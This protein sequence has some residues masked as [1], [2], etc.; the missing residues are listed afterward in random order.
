[1]SASKDLS[2][3]NDKYSMGSYNPTPEELQSYLNGI[4]KGIRIAPKRH[5]D[6][7]YIEVYAK[8]RWRHNGELFGPVDVW[9]EIYNY[10]C[11]YEK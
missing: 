3:K 11:Y 4:R 9:K 2:R 7:W 10:Y 5:K 1:M 8:D 6:K